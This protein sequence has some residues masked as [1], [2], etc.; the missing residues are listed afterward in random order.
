V[1]PAETRGRGPIGSWDTV[2]IMLDRSIVLRGDVVEDDHQ[3][4]G[5]RH[6]ALAFVDAGAEWFCTLS[7]VIDRAGRLH[8]GALEIEGCRG[9]GS[10]VLDEVLE[11]QSEPTLELA[12]IFH[13]TESGSDA[14]IDS[15]GWLMRL[16]QVPSTD[17][18]QDAF[19]AT[20]APRV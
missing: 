8:E 20:L 7:L 14:D 16:R 3:L 10:A 13:D 6:L 12:A 11:L 15:T 4:D 5:S 2:R 1:V 19:E 18:E 9:D 17:D